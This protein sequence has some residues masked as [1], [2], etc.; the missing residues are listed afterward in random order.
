MVQKSILSVG[1]T[2]AHSIILEDLAN[3]EPSNSINSSNNNKKKNGEPLCSDSSQQRQEDVQEEGE[4]TWLPATL[5]D[6]AKQQS[7]SLLYILNNT[8]FP[9]W[10]YAYESGSTKAQREMKHQ[11]K[12]CTMKK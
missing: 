6:E 12:V 7:G 8:R 9:K 4:G 5:E 11:I 10:Y 1:D 2:L 3:T